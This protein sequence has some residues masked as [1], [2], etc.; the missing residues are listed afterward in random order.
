MMK[1]NNKPS[2]G[3]IAR[4]SRTGVDLGASR[5]AARDAMAEMR[6]RRVKYG[7]LS[8]NRGNRDEPIRNTK[9]GK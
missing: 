1:P 9:R 3:P 2:K 4:L 5:N 6:E 8:I 7:R